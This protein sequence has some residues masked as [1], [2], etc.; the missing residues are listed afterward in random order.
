MDITENHSPLKERILRQ[1]ATL[2]NKQLDPINRV[3][4]SS[5]KGMDERPARDKQLQENVTKEPKIT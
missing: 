5:A 2:H 4:K 1:R 3:A